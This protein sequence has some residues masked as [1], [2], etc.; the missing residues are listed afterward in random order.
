V[1][2]TPNDDDYLILDPI[3]PAGQVHDQPR[4]LMVKYGNRVAGQTNAINLRNAIQST[5]VY[6]RN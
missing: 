5:I 1:Q 3:V 4:S 2:R 6:H